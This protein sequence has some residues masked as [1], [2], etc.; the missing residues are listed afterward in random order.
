MRTVSAILF[1]L[2]LALAAWAGS[3][4]GQWLARVPAKDAAR[5]NPLAHDSQAKAAGALL[6]EQHCASC[7]GEDAHGKENKPNLHS[8]HVA[9]AT[10]GQLFWLL[11]NGSL[12]NGMPSWSRL[13]EQQ[14]WAVVAY[15]KS[16]DSH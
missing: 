1:S 12:K 9:A 7:H 16:L 6:F 4:D 14:R 5:T 11:T 8:E 15:L 10:P 3:G 13:P 2:S